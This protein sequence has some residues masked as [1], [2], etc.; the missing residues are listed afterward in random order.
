MKPSSKN[1]LFS[2]FKIQMESFLDSGV[3]T[4]K[5]IV[6]NEQKWKNFL[7]VSQG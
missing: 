7:D 5:K 6:K 4:L 2:L 1:S 3:L